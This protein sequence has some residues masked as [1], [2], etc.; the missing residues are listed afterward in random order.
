MPLSYSQLQ[1]YRRCPKQYEFAAVKKVP[2]A[3]SPGESFGTSIHNTLKK[4]GEL[5]LALR[6]ETRGAARDQLTLLSEQ[7]T[8]ESERSLQ[9]TTLLTL[10]RE[11]FVA[12]GYASR[13][14]QD[15]RILQGEAALTHFFAWW[16][17]EERT[18]LGIE[19]SFRITVPGMPG[20]TE[21][22]G[23]IDRIERTPKGLRITDFKSSTPCTQHEADNDLQLS[24]Y[25]VAAMEKWGEEVTELTLLYL[26]EEQIVERKTIRTIGQRKDALIAVRTLAERILSGDYRPTPSVATCRGCPYRFICGARAV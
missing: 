6:R 4:W 7:N 5:E 11:S 22:S 12:E 16:K 10:W 9:L 23:R 15:A 19:T 1:T 21:L 14:E 3:V 26:G 2:R 13:A 24:L 17:Q 18:V 8:H 25:A 20:N